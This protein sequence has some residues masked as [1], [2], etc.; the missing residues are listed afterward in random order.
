ML[1]A[2]AD[3]TTAEIDVVSD[4]ALKRHI[5]RQRETV[6]YLKMRILS[7][8]TIRTAQE[9]LQKLELAATVSHR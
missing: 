4:D 5:A 8:V 1:A 6:A 2:R 9:L 7:L 3:E